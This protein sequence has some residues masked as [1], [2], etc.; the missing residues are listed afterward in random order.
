MH[1][2]SVRMEAEEA[3]RMPKLLFNTDMT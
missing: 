1:L 2:T 3:S